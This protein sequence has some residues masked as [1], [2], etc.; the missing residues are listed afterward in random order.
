MIGS[1]EFEQWPE[2]GFAGRAGVS[3]EDNEIEDDLAVQLLGEC[4]D[5]RDSQKERIAL[6]LLG[7]G[8]HEIPVGTEQLRRRVEAVHD[9]T[10]QH[11]RADLVCQPEFEGCDD[12]VKLPPPPRSA[13]KRS[14]FSSALARTSLPSAVTI[15]AEIRLSMAMPCLRMR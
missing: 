15:S 10:G 14:G 5:R 11:L 9:L 3:V 6:N 7:G 4:R 1:P 2:R 12:A 13:Q 8:R